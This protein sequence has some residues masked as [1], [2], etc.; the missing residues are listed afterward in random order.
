MVKVEECPM[1]RDLIEIKYERKNTV[2]IETKPIVED[3]WD[4]LD[5]LIL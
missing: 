1:T 2:N 5:T 4:S 3:N